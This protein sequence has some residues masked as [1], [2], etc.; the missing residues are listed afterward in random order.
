MPALVVEDGTGIVTANAYASVAEIDDI[1]SYH[2]HATAWEALDPTVK[3]KLAI[4]S[5][6]I[7]DT[8]VRW[9][10]TK[11]HDTSGLAWPRTG[12]C[13]REGIAIDDNIVP[14]QVKE[15]IAVLSKH[16]IGNDPDEVNSA[17]NLEAIQA[18]V[19]MLKF[20]PKLNVAK[21]PDS[22]N[23]ILKGLGRASMGHGGPKRIVRY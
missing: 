16:L 3:E 22:I 8:R 23:Y 12:A 11:T 21:F 13:D 7:L 4:W 1:L 2:I 5:S 6:Q 18:D 10:G 15:A 14:H 19:V 17:S 20:D 9:A